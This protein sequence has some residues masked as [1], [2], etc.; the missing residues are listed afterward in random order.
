MKLKVI[1]FAVAVLVISQYGFAAEEAVE[2]VA[3]QAMEAVMV[4]NKICPISGEK[5]DAMG[6]AK[7]VEY[8]GKHYN[9][10]CAACE[11]DF[12]K[13]PAAAVKKIEE[14]MAAEVK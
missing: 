9:L 5:V 4:D 11:K 6:E 8:N 12:L 1:I 2:S 13:D 10:C 7:V 3:G 14:V